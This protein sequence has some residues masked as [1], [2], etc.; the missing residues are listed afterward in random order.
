[1]KFY[2]SVLTVL[3]CICSYSSFASELSPAC[4]DFIEKKLAPNN[5]Q[6]GIVEVPENWDDPSSLKIKIFYYYKAQTKQ[7]A[8]AVF[9]FNGGPFTSYQNRMEAINGLLMKYDNPNNP[10]M[11]VMMDQRGVGCSTPNVPDAT[12]D[13]PRYKLYD[14]SQI[15]R[16]AEAIRNILHPNSAWKIYAQSAGGFNSVRYLQLFPQSVQELHLFAPAFHES[17]ADFFWMRTQKNLQVLQKFLDFY[18]QEKDQLVQALEKIN[19]PVGQSYCIATPSGEVCGA[20][21]VD[22]ILT[23]LGQGHGRGLGTTEIWDGVKSALIS[24]YLSDPE[25][26]DVNKQNFLKSV[27]ENA[28]FY[29][30]PSALMVFSFWAGELTYTTG[31]LDDDCDAADS[32]LKEKGVAVEFLLN[33]HC[34]IIRAIS[35]LNHKAA[36]AENYASIR[37]KDFL[38]QDKIAALFDQNK[39]KVYLYTAELDSLV[40]V[41]SLKTL[42]DSGT[43]QHQYFEGIGHAGWMFE[44]SVWNKLLE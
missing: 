3:V 22:T 9:F 38:T 32:I 41:E 30:K 19:S 43:T 36:L 13:I 33:N 20:S 17:M 39:T 21:L 28:S 34:R 10:H 29:F 23:S 44:P 25:T 35:P 16:D 2:L 8:D 24:L 42:I 40:Q 14:S 7:N 15:A 31:F 27:L 4:Q 5:W 18:P 12:I 11:F 1:M 6:W 26:N 37:G